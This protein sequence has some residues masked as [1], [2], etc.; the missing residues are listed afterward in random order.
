MPKAYQTGFSTKTQPLS[1]KV[2]TRPDIICRADANLA[3]RLVTGPV[4]TEAPLAEKKTNTFVSTC[5]TLRSKGVERLK[6]AVGF[7]QKSKRFDLIG[8]LERGHRTISSGLRQSLALRH[9][10]HRSKGRGLWI[11]KGVVL[12][13]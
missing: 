5:L 12:E 4:S 8:L 13:L 2:K 7:D 11:F 6:L 9:E 10:L 3:A 1:C